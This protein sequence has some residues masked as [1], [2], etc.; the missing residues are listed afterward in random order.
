MSTAVAP[1]RRPSPAAARNPG[2]PEDDTGTPTAAQPIGSRDWIV[3]AICG[4]VIICCLDGFQER[5]CFCRHG[6]FCSS[7]LD[8]SGF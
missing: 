3:E 2:R 8:S 1:P 6:L 5:T 4:G 7:S